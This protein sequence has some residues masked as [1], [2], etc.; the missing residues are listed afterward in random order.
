MI[1]AIA[2]AF[3]GI[4]GAPGEAGQI[5]SAINSGL[6]ALLGGGPEKTQPAAYLQ[7]IVYD[8]NLNPTGQKGYYVGG[9]ELCAT[10]YQ[11]TEGI[12]RSSK[13]HNR[14]CGSC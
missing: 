9:S 3:G 2:A 11:K 7:Y 8:V 12:R 13:I 5:Y 4:S 14:R 6:S 10:H 1:T